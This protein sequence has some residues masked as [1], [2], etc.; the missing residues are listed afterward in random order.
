MLPRKRSAPPI[1]S[2]AGKSAPENFAALERCASAGGLRIKRRTSQSKRL[3]KKI[4]LHDLAS[5]HSTFRNSL[6]KRAA[7]VYSKHACEHVSCV[8]ACMKT[9]VLFDFSMPS[10]SKVRSKQQER[11]A[12]TRQ[13]LLDA[14]I[15]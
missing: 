3:A 9:Y 1:T 15:Q 8:L 7:K 4:D 5:R 13:L 6:F 2:S 11:S 12:E 10:T 14:T